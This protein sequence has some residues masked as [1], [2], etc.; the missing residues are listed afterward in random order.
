MK[1]RL[2]LDL[3]GNVDAQGI[4]TLLNI[5]EKEGFS[6]FV[7]RTKESEECL[8]F[9]VWEKYLIDDGGFFDVK[10]IFNGEREVSDNSLYLTEEDLK[11][12]ERIACQ[13]ALAFKGD[14][15]SGYSFLVT[16]GAFY[17]DFWGKPLHRCL[18]L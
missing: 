9:C 15:L 7:L 16:M 17:E 4:L 14:T 18:W 13:V 6:P 11:E 5:L 12:P 2:L 1:K 10:L 3:R 8:P